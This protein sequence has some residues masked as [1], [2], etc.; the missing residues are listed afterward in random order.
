MGNKIN[1]NEVK[2]IVWKACDTFRGL[3]NPDQYKDYIL[4][5][6]FIKYVSDVHNE[7]TKEY[8]KKYN[9]DAVRA[10]RAMKQERFIVPENSSFDFLYKRRNEVNIGELI[11]IALTDFEEANR[12]KLNSEDGSGVFRN[13]DLF[14]Y[15]ATFEEIK[16]N[17]FNLNIPR[18]VDTFEEEAEVDIAAVQKEIEVLET[19]LAEVQNEMK[20]YLTVLGA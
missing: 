20:K 5:M 19:E 2:Q 15:I 9:G 13:I 14:S 8:L 10:E 6:L 4:T 3:I 18:Y 11:N 12:Q 1:S 16:E 7:K 17:D